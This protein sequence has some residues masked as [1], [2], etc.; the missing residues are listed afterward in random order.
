MAIFI[1]VFM[2]PGLIVFDFIPKVFGKP[3]LTKWYVDKYN[4]TAD[5]L[6]FHVYIPFTFIL[7]T[8][9]LFMYFQ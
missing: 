9:I 4:K 6:V 3:G 1:L 2:I 7:L 8:A 5:D